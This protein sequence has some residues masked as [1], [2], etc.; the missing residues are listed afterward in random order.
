M[1]NTPR[2]SMGSSGAPR[3]TPCGHC[4]RTC[5]EYIHNYE[6]KENLSAYNVILRQFGL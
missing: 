5:G 1:M 4:N 6:K 2:S 3:T